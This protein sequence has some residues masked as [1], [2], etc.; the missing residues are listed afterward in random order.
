ML[1]PPASVVSGTLIF[2]PY[3]QRLLDEPKLLI[4]VRRWGQLVY[5]LSGNGENYVLSSTDPPFMGS[6][7]GCGGVLASTLGVICME[8]QRF[9]LHFQAGFQNFV[10]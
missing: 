1:K 7:G 3:S 9:S 8:K 10:L 2:S 5:A 6:F 4:A